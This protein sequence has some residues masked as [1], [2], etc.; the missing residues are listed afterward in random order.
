MPAYP[1]NIAQLLLESARVS[2]SEFERVTGPDGPKI[3]IETIVVHPPSSKREI[4]I[5]PEWVPVLKSL[6]LT[7]TGKQ[8]VREPAPQPD[9]L[10]TKAEVAKKLKLSTRG[11][12]CL[13]SSGTL[14]AIWMSRK[15]VRFRWRDVLEDIRRCEN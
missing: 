13:V 5:G 10:L 6:F 8:E 7:S 9:D 14:R 3:A 12:D 4:A 2:V 11:V 15:I 1:E